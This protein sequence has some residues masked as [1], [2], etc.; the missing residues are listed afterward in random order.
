MSEKLRPS[1]SFCSFVHF[2][3]SKYILFKFELLI[4][5][6]IF[7]SRPTVR[8]KAWLFVSMFKTLQHAYLKLHNY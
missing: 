7:M 3:N 8:I 2:V 5:G 4:L 1:F 6:L